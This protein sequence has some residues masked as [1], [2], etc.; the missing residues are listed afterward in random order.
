MAFRP[1]YYNDPWRIREVTDPAILAKMNVMQIYRDDIWRRM[2]G[3]LVGVGLCTFGIYSLT[4][5]PHAPD[6]V[7]ADRAMWWGITLN[8]AGIAAFLLSW[9]APDLSGIWCRSPRF[10]PKK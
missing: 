10:P 3:A 5:V 4:M 2:G 1:S 8:V 9:L 7:L 6:A